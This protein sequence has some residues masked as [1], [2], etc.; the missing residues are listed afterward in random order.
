M[1][2]SPQRYGGE[3]QT[4]VVTTDRKSWA[5]TEATRSVMQANRSRDTKHELAIRRI[6][7]KQGRRYRVNARPLEGDRHTAEIVFR[8][9]KVAEFVDG[10]FW[11]RCV[12][13][14][15]LPK[16]NTEFWKAKIEDNVLGDRE[17]S[18]VLKQNGWL[19][20]RVW[21]HE[22]PE[23]VARRIAEAVRQRTR[24]RS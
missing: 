15:K 17:T 23:T 1:S 10:C 16:S 12:T 9:A 13:D 7:H 6:L 4:G 22:N 18:L 3:L 5:T 21:E 8:P 11:H 2:G 19:V 24:Y 14:K 20:M